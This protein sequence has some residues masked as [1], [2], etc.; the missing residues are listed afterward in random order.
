MRSARAGRLAAFRSACLVSAILV[1][2]SFSVSCRARTVS[3]FPWMDSSGA[4]MPFVQRAGWPAGEEGRFAGGRRSNT[5][6]LERS[7]SAA[8]GSTIAVRLR[9]VSDG[10]ARVRLSLSPDPDGS[11]PTISSSFPILS[12]RVSLVVSLEADSRVASLSLSSEGRATDF[13]VESI[14][15]GPA[16]KGIDGGGPDLRVSTGFALVKARGYQELSIAKPFVG[17]SAVRTGVLIEYGPSPRG[18]S[19]SLDAL[20]EGGEALSYTIRAQPAGARTTLD[21]AILPLDAGIIRLRVPAG[22]EVKAFFASELGVDDYELADLGRVLLSTAP[23]P[24]YLVYRW[25][26]LP[27]VLVFDFKD[28]ATHDRYLK[29]LAFFTE[30]L[31]FRGTLEKD[32]AIAAL[33]GWNAHDYGPE[34]LASFYRAAR[35]RSFPLGVEERE[36]EGILLRSGILEEGGGRIYPGKGAIISISRESGEALR[37][38]FAVHES[39]HAIFFADPDYRSFARALWSSVDP[40]ERWFWRTYFAWAGYDVGS[41]YLMG[42]EFQAYLLQQPVA[43]AVAYFSKRKSAELLAKHPELKAKL[44]AYMAEFGGSFAQRAERLEAWLNVKYGVEAGRTFFLAR[45]GG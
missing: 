19:M 7:V 36:L 21:A 35:E 18:A 26:M 17:R 24:G 2:V 20:R 5:Y 30:K 6:A 39:A 38:T 13:F 34:D 28:Y 4:P 10:D 16:F 29:R 12:E 32:E 22:V 9:H 43:E 15:S 14:V 33:R 25:D 23:D 1:S 8:A 3:G 27:S 37:R 45:R 11:S 41:D 42:N 40:R 31:G 44:E